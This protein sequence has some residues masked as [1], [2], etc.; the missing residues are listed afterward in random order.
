[1]PAMKYFFALAT[2]LFVSGC[3]LDVSPDDRD[4]FYGGWTHP[5][6]G[7]QERMYGRKHASSP[8]PDDTARHPVP[9]AEPAR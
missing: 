7:A 6:K 9:D 1:M 5:E 3:A 4:F 2:A 8:S